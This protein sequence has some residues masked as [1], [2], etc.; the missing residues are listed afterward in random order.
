[1]V[2]VALLVALIL[3]AGASAAINPRIN[4]QGR[5]ADTAGIGV[6][7]GTYNVEFKLHNDAA[8]TG[9]AQGAC[10][11]SCLWMET[12]TG[13]ARVTVTRGLFSVQLGEVASLAAFNF[14]Q[15]PLY[16]SVRV[17]GTAA[18]PA[19]DGEMTPRH[20][21]GAAP[22]A[23]HADNAAK[24]GGQAPSYYSNAGN[25]TGTVADARL[26]ANVA[27]RD[28]NN[29]FSVGQTVT[30][31]VAATDLTCADCLNAA[32]VAL[33]AIGTSEIADGTVSLVDLAANSVDSSKI[34]DGSV[35]AADL[36]APVTLQSTSSVEQTGAYTADLV[37]DSASVTLTQGTWMVSAHATITSTDVGEGHQIGLYDA[38]LSADLPNTKSGV[39]DGGVGVHKAM[40]TSGI[41]TVPSGTMLLKIKG[42]RNGGST[43]RFGY[44][45]VL[46]AE[47]RITAVRLSL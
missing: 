37:Y 4:F 20:R 47:Q 29:N 45:L 24:L 38:T 17:G 35:T 34:V 43:L 22:Q 32:D 42:Y 8:L 9:G 5:L 18:V 14:D 21:L 46:D 25:L 27:L 31:T 30:G 1:M 10:T 40:S 2:A 3:P 26:S 7:D 13:A 44:P 12:R 6:P 39:M 23:I 19:W 28:V 16:L 41:V 11:G 36:A 15:D 33:G